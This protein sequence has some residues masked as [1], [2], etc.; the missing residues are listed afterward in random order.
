MQYVP[1]RGETISKPREKRAARTLQDEKASTN[2]DHA[3]VGKA[4]DGCGD[5]EA[6]EIISVCG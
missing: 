1:I 5:Y 3:L 4:L 2:N 6:V